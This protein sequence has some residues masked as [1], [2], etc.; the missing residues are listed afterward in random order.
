MTTSNFLK[1]MHHFAKHT[2]PTPSS[3]VLLLLDNHKSHISVSVL[4][5]CK[6]SGIVLLN[7]PPHCSHKLQPLDLTVYGPLKNYY[8][9]AVTDCL[10]GNPDKTVI[11]Y[12]IPKLAALAVPHAFKQQN[13][14]RGFEKSGIWPMN[15]NI[16]SDE[17]FLCSTVT[18]RF[19]TATTTPGTDNVP[20]EQR[21]P[22]QA[23]AEQLLT[24]ENQSQVDPTSS[25]NMAA[26]GSFQLESPIRNL[27]EE[28][29]T[30]TPHSLKPY[31][32]AGR[33]ETEERK[34]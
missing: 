27:T 11:I 23:S 6:E 30:I 28:A 3:P 31:P 21:T 2:K 5:F 9:T 1:Y 15:S 16:F 22:S 17:D 7:F 18:D 10:V 8:N 12:E 24:E 33:Y 19:D 32:K 13:I 34:N 25:N 26:S 4:D 29:E 14:E 20:T